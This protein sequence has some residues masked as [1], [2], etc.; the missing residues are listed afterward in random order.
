MSSPP[1]SKSTRYKRATTFFLDSLLR[2]RV[3][4]CHGG[5]SVNLK[6]LST[7]VVKVARDP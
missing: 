6:T 1:L 5:K 7:I 4:G 2:A 3:R